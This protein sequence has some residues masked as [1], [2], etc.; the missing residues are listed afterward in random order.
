[1]QSKQ[2]LIKLN[3]Q[4]RKRLINQN[5]I[6]VWERDSFKCKYCG[7]DMLELYKKWR[8]GEIDRVQGALITIDHVIPRSKGGGWEIDNL[9]T[10]CI[11]CN[12]E[13]ADTVF[14]LQKKLDILDSLWGITPL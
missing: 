6:K 8:N 2:G 13:K 5:R 3:G 12:N 4:L 10:A 9:V 1:M 14:G 7:L 11:I